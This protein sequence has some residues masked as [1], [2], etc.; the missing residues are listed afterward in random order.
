MLYERFR[1]SKSIY[2]KIRKKDDFN[3]FSPYHSIRLSCSLWVKAMHI[4]PSLE[5]DCLPLT[6]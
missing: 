4:S 5:G 2:E 6:A 1:K 3:N